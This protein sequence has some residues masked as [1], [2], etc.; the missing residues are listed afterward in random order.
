MLA[1]M[2]VDAILEMFAAV[3]CTGQLC[4]RDLD[5]GQEVGLA[6]DQQVVAASVFKVLVAVVAEAGCAEGWLDPLHQVTLPPDGRTP[7]PTG[8]SLFQ[9]ETTAT[10]R[11]LVVAMLTISDNVATDALLREIG[12]DR[13]NATAERLGLASTFIPGNIYR[14]V[15]SIAVDAGFDDWAAMQAWEAT[16]PAKDDNAS[17]MR[18]VLAGEALD[19]SRTTR[20][21]A[22]DMARLLEL[23]WAE[24]AAPPA[25]CDRVRQIMARQLTRHRLARASRRRPRSPRRAAA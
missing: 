6:A 2:D 17:R 15:N 3:E 19:P 10:L 18:A 9:D 16:S 13:V 1:A 7:G 24:T 8:F 25:A 4:V 23:I 22:R 11:D 21:S 5:T 14:M 20:T 12:I